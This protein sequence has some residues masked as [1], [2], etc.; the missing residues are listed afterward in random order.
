MVNAEHAALSPAQIARFQEQGF[1]LLP[2][3]IDPA[4][5]EP[6]IQEFEGIIDSYARQ[7]HADGRLPDPFTNAPFDRRLAL[8]HGAMEDASDL[9]RLLHG[10]NQKTAG[11]FAIFTHP[12]CWMSWRR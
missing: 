3:L 12:R 1:L 11:M 4:V 5:F 7:A 8:I 6:L 2:G 9:W 10:K